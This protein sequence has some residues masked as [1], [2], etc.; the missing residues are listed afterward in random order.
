MN[1]LELKGRIG[2]VYKKPSLNSYVWI[3][4]CRHFTK[5]KVIAK[6]DELFFHNC[7]NDDYVEEFREPVYYESYGDRWFR[8][9]KEIRQKYKIKKVKDDYYEVSNN[10]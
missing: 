5:V 8:S 1:G 7:Y 4:Y 2:H 3:Y 10:E 9:L 6:G